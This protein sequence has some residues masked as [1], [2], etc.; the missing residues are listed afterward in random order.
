MTELNKI[1]NI[2][3]PWISVNREREP[4]IVTLKSGTR[5]ELWIPLG[6][7]VEIEEAG[8]NIRAGVLGAREQGTKAVG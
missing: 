3:D 5:I 4:F 8:Y 1:Y 7:A 2:Y 6:A